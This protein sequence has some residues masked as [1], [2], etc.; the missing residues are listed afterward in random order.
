[1]IA[2]K[3]AKLSVV[4][5]LLEFDNP[6]TPA[7]LLLRDINGSIPLHV[8]VKNGHAKITKL[9]INAS[10]TNGKS[11][12]MEDGVGCTPLETAGLQYLL[13][14][15]DT[16]GF[17]GSIVSPPTITPLDR[18]TPPAQFSAPQFGVGPGQLTLTEHGL[19][20]APTPAVP[21][22]FPMGSTS[23]AF[24]FASPTPAPSSSFQMAL[25]SGGMQIASIGEEPSFNVSAIDLENRIT[26]A[27]NRT[28]KKEVE[29]LEEVIGSLEAEGRFKEKQNL[30]RVL[31]EY[32]ETCR[33]EAAKWD[34][35]PSE[36]KT[37][38]EDTD[39]TQR[40]ETYRLI[41]GAVKASS[42]RELV[43]LL[44]AQRAVAGALDDAVS[45]N[46]LRNRN[47][48]VEG[49]KLEK[50]NGSVLLFPVNGNLFR[51]DSEN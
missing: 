32:V 14:K 42:K 9:L 2:V 51:E 50:R 27:Y 11:L 40:E 47:M 35:E 36:E 43:H 29:L 7:S 38:I 5:C 49:K 39:T 46:Y 45:K 44:D 13:W 18:Y 10:P 17:K 16:S 20:T 33:E 6:V 41:S 24:S 31:K 26:P 3:G 21:Q 25:P 23:N 28:S 22:L 8:A 30:E 4:K 15:T 1:M 48:Y 34:I 19:V 12:F 37:D